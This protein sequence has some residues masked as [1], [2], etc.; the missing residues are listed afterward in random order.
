MEK[1]VGY[2]QRRRIRAQIRVAKKKQETD[3]VVST[4]TTRETI[5]TIKRAISPERQP[6]SHTP[7]YHS[8]S[9]PQ[10]SPEREPKSHERIVSP[11]RQPTPQRVLSPEFESKQKSVPNKSLSPERQSPHQKSVSPERTRAKESGSALPNG[12]A[13]EPSKAVTGKRPQSPAKLRHNTTPSSR[14]PMRPSSPDKKTRPVSPTKAATPKPKSNRFSEYATAYMKKIGLKSEEVKTSSAKPKKSPARQVPENVTKQ[15]RT[16]RTIDE[17]EVRTKQTTT[18][19][20]KNVTERTAS[21][22]II[23]IVDVNGKRSASPEKQRSPERRTQSPEKSR[24]RSPDLVRQ[25]EQTPK[26]KET[27]VKTVNDIEKKIP[28]KQQQEEKP[29]WVTNRNLKKVSSTVRSYSSKK[30]DTEKQKYRAPSPSKVI[31]KPIDVIT[32]SYGPGP[33]DADGRPLFGIKA[34]RNGATNYQGNYSF[35]AV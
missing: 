13:K 29:S 6:R 4:K 34:L 9:S 30:I 22:D 20:I 15:E 18:S 5:T 35:L 17:E 23:E 8:R 3:H 27:I 2:E 25:V 1:V 33:L 19:V 28:S 12:H 26:K 16:T 7:E 14:S 10:K 21:K 24:S 11:A 32:S 31:S